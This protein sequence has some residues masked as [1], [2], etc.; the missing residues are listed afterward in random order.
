M[1]MLCADI[2]ARLSRWLVREGPPTQVPLCDFNRLSYELRPG[3]VLLV[4]GRSRISE[5]I[6]L[7]T[8]S[9]WTHAALYIGRMF[10]IDDK[11]L[12][13]KI[14]AGYEGDPGDQLLVE[15]LLGEGTIIAPLNKYRHHHVRICRPAG[16]NPGDAQQVINY[17]LG[18]LGYAYDVRHLLDLARFIF[19]WNILPRRWR[20]S[21]FQHNAGVPTRTVCSSLLATAFSTVNFPILPFIDRSEDGGVRFYKR[22]PRLFTPRDFDNSP[23]FEIIKYPFLGIDD[24]G[25][26]RRLPWSD[27]PVLYNDNDR[28]FTAQTQ[29]SKTQRDQ[30]QRITDLAAHRSRRP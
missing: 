9:T 18:H 24:I 7:I 19:P 17:T 26:Y 23:Y 15:A 14:R 20:S 3:D 28:E 8:Q 6:K 29:A 2:S 4:E 27:S 12:Q 13:A 1:A 16:L 10:D 30:E 22:N 21:L 25:L 11:R 5:V